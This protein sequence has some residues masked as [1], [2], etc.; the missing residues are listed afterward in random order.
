MQQRIRP[1]PAF[2]DAGG[3]H[4]DGLIEGLALQL[5]VGRGATHQLEEVILNPLF[6]RRSLGDDLLRQ[7]LNRRFGLA[8][9]VEVAALDGADHRRAFDELV[10]R[11]GEERAVRNQSEGVTGAS[12]A[13]KEG[14]DPARRTDL[15]DQVD[16]ADVDAQLKR[17]R[18]HDGLEVA[19]LEPLLHHVPTLLGQRAVVSRDMLLADA[20]AE[21]MRNPLSQRAT[22]DED[23]RCPVLEDQLRQSVVHRAP[24]FVCGKRLER[25]V[26]CLNPELQLAPVPQVEDAAGQRLARCVKSGQERRNLVHRLLRRGQTDPSRPLLRDVVESG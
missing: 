21:L 12:D 15:T 13:L 9:A 7:N 4:V 18:R 2:A 3:Q 14:R 1:A 26:G 25:R 11:R 22:I 16:R 8:D 10:Q 20:D 24:M 23:Q 17:R 6:L 19:V 5:A